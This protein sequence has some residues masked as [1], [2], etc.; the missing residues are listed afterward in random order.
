MQD[1]K[2]KI[3][4]PIKELI[5]KLPQVG[6]LEWIGI[7]KVRREALTSLQTVNVTVDEGLEGDHFKS[8]FSKKRQVTIIQQEHLNG[9][10]SMLGQDEISPEK[11]RRN[12]V[13]SGIN[14]FALR[15]RKF[16]I[17]DVIFEGTGYCH[18]CSRMEENLGPGGYNAMRGHGGITVQVVSGGTIKIRDE[19]KLI[20]E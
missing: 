14:L 16:S 5:N 9:V 10:A 13:V 17:G 6:K 1:M 15:D 18:P 11:T 12:L 3:D 2:P 19:V 20:K 8:K 4:E 7:R